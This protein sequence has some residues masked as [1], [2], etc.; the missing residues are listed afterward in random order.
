LYI[1]K[2]DQTKVKEGRQEREKIEYQLHTLKKGIQ[3]LEF[4]FQAIVAATLS[5][6]K[7]NNESNNKK[8]S[9]TM[10]RYTREAR[11]YRERR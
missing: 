5:P 1:K 4:C 9:W 3:D 7:N 2:I 11:P 6:P 10:W 8:N